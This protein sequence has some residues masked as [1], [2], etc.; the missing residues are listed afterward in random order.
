MD[1]KG[2]RAGKRFDVYRNNV[3]VSLIG[4]METAFPAVRGVVGA[5][6]FGKMAS[7]YVRQHPPQ[8]PLLMFYGVEFP[9]FLDG[10][11]PVDTLPYLP[12]LARLEL[13]RR[14][15]YHAADAEAVA[16]DALIALGDD[17]DEARVTF[18][19]SF[20]VLH[21]DHP[22]HSHW[23]RQNGED[24]AAIPDGPETILLARP[25]LDVV[26]TTITRGAAVFLEQLQNGETLGTATE[27]A[28][29]LEQDFDLSAILG[30]VL[31][32]KTIKTIK[33]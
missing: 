25:D 28:A 22:V 33:I 24:I 16:P 8:S 18:V 23:L 1:P 9:D 27:A 2:R 6:F 20:A 19:P 11:A 15:T 3:I 10:F 5:E 13:A 26:T 31:Q 12:D 29:N 4:A 32:L 7:L 14:D 21:A 30:L 17:L